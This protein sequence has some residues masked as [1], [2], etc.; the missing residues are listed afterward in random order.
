MGNKGMSM[1]MM[2][3][4][5]GMQELNNMSNATMDQNASM[6][7]EDLSEMKKNLGVKPANVNY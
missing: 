7:M 1:G 3:K 5:K 6:Q 2:G 4:M